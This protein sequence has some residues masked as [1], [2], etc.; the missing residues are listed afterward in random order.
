MNTTDRR[1]LSRTV[2]VCLPRDP[3]PEFR[4]LGGSDSDHFNQMLANQTLNALWV[5]HS[6]DDQRNRQ[7]LAACA[8]LIGAKPQNELEGM[9][10]SQMI[11]CHAASLEST[12]GPCSPSRA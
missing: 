1:P 3:K 9:L 5:A 2:E 6:D 8:A 10:V 4:Q 11:A 7:F 12:A